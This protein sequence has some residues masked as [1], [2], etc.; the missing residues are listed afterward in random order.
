[1]AQVKVY[2]LREHLDPIKVQL[3][4]A[5]HA[6]VVQAFDFPRDK[7]NHRFFPLE[8]E[9]FFFPDGRTA[10]YTI[11]E[12]SLFEGRT[13]AA[14][15]SLIRLLFQRAQECGIAPADLEIALTETPREN[16]GI[17]GLPADELELN[18]T[19]EV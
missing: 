4:D 15:K 9:D 13:I 5:I 6:C 8:P 18:Y 17:R 1:M 12:I 19:V 3:S 10:R 14:K 2:G 16:W 11:I 7:K